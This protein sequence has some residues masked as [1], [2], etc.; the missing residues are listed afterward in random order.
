[1]LGEETQRN[2]SRSATLSST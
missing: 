1:M 2:H